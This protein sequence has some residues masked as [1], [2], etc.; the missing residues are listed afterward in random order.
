VQH[1]LDHTFGDRVLE[2][3]SLRRAGSAPLP[4][5]EDGA[6]RRLVYFHSRFRLTRDYDFTAWNNL[7]LSA[8]ANLLGATDRGVQGVAEG[9]NRAGDE[10]RVYGSVE[11][12][13]RGDAWQ[14]AMAARLAPGRPI[15]T[16]GPGQPTADIAAL[17]QVR[18]LLAASSGRQG[19]QRRI[20]IE[21]ETER[22]LG[23]IRLRLDR[24][25]RV[26]VLAA[27]PA[28]GTYE[29][30]ARI[31]A[32]ALG[33][34][35]RRFSPLATEGSLENLRRL[36]EGSVELALVQADLAGLAF[37]GRGAFAGEPPMRNL[38]ALA[39]L[40][41]EAVHVVVAADSGIRRLE[42]LA[43]RRVDI[44]LPGSG[45]RVHALALLSAVG[46]SPADL[47]EARDEGLAG[48]VAALE[49]GRLDGFIATIH[50]PAPQIQRL[51]AEGRIRL[52]SL[53]EPIVARLRGG[54]PFLVP[55]RLP[56]GTYAGVPEPISTVA[57][58][59]L[60]AANRDLPPGEVEGLLR[61]LFER[62]DFAAQ[63]SAAGSQIA[64]RTAR[65]GLSI[66]LHDAAE[67]FL[68]R[69]PAK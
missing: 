35:G 68:N 59:A 42:D 20:I 26:G 55:L 29:G 63:G 45:T 36:R 17:G 30:V 22:A 69:T 16:A 43:G 48:A 15:E 67:A 66:P 11:F 52:L 62:I 5:A 40:F 39:S 38:R 41:P 64:V 6:P 65:D 57:V 51:A 21:E 14:P 1:R 12:A 4:A 13:R 18:A 46:L 27:G 37:A 3:F 31:V 50:A 23:A 8:L 10:L 7:N 61:T 47:G 56:L 49:A 34:N 53:D 9:G 24:L 32:A 19:E 2:L 54:E 60:L 25:E 33:N 28:G 44:G 58:A